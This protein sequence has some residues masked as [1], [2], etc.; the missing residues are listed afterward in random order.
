MA[1]GHTPEVQAYHAF[2]ARM[3]R[4]VATND[5]GRFSDVTALTEAHTQGNPRSCVI[6]ERDRQLMKL[7]REPNEPDYPSVKVVFNNIKFNNIP[8]RAYIPELFGPRRTDPE[9]PVEAECDRCGGVFEAAYLNDHGEEIKPTVHNGALYDRSIR[10][11]IDSLDT[12]CFPA[13][14]RIPAISCPRPDICQARTQREYTERMMFDWPYREGR[15]LVHAHP[16]ETVRFFRRLGFP[17]GCLE[18][19]VT[20]KIKAIP[21]CSEA[22]ANYLA[23]RLIWIETTIRGKTIHHDLPRYH[24][25]GHIGADILLWKMDLIKPMVLEAIYGMH[26]TSVFKVWKIRNFWT[27]R[28]I[29]HIAA[30]IHHVEP[31]DR[32]RL[33]EGLNTID[34]IL[35]SGG[36]AV[37]GNAEA[38]FEVDKLLINHLVAYLLRHIDVSSIGRRLVIRQ[39]FSEAQ[40]TFAQL[41]LNIMRESKE[42]HVAKAGKERKRPE[43]WGGRW[44]VEDH[45][46]E[47][48]ELFADHLIQMKNALWT[49]EPQYL[50]ACGFKH[51]VAGCLCPLVYEPVPEGDPALHVEVGPL[52]EGE[53]APPIDVES[54]PEEVPASQIWGWNP[55]SAEHLEAWIMDLPDNWGD[56]EPEQQSNGNDEEDGNDEGAQAPE[57][58][59]DDEDTEMDYGEDGDDSEDDDDD[60]DYETESDS[61]DSDDEDDD[62][63]DQGHV[64]GHQ[65][66][67]RIYDEDLED[68]YFTIHEEEELLREPQHYVLHQPEEPQD[69]VVDQQQAAEPQGHSFR[70]RPEEDWE[71]GWQE[72]EEHAHDQIQQAQANVY[73]P[74]P[75]QPVYQWHYPA[76]GASWSPLSA[77]QAPVVAPSPV[78]SLPAIYL[79]PMPRPAFLL[80]HINDW[81]QRWH[82]DANGYHWLVGDSDM[83]TYGWDVYSRG[84]VVYISSFIG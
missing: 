42:W 6:S 66:Y 50:C 5:K 67:P 45:E 53:P 16:D 28:Q 55:Y 79:A 25:W 74:P 2:R 60:E 13:K 26:P 27:I 41:H 12:T 21:F 54:V 15:Q 43:I 33:Q 73:A 83:R 62:D 10:V 39:G 57:E 11:A 19:N 4:F 76:Y 59:L 78:Y 52:P 29:E 24:M 65:Q 23:Y 82:I 22:Y 34:D 63:M 56:R 20:A 69:L 3:D 80:G 8:H 1:A 38:E 72:A 7:A 68:D 84:P 49:T 36:E 81:G 64:L 37:P 77:P 61:S 32:A 17:R 31:A 14:A 18:D 40:K 30:I 44:D 75:P 9:C 47:G 48:W 71:I 70:Q 46:E 35:M 51:P 58:D